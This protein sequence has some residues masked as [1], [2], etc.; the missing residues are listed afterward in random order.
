MAFID[1]EKAFDRVLRKVLQWSLRTLGVEEWIIRII[2][3]MYDGA[4]TA[5]KL[6]GGESKEFEVKVGVHQGSAL[7]PLLFTIVLEALSREFKEGLPFEILYADDL[8]LLAESAKELMEKVMC[9][10]VALEAKGLKV[11][12]GKQR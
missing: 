12:M 11:N 3:S 4:M 7:N 9:W 1:L 10:K 8:A 6:K 5:V 2:Q